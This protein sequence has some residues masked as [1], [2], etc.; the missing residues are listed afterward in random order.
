MQFMGCL[1][2]GKTISTKEQEIVKKIYN[3]QL[4]PDLYLLTFSSNSDN[5]LELIPEREIL[6]KNYPD[7]YLKVIGIANG[8]NE[9][10]QVLQDIIAE[11]IQKTKSPDIR[12]Y[13][14]GKWE[15]QACQ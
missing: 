15:E 4:V 7:Q 3:H 9:A 6:Q 14:I 2:V 11:S 10:I 12:E 1:Y 5:M 13:L 8:K